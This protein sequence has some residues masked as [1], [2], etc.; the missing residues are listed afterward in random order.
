V[1]QAQVPGPSVSEPHSP[2]RSI[3][4]VNPGSV[5]LPAYDDMHPFKHHVET[6]SPHARYAIVE[7]TAQ[8]WHTELR[9]VPY[10]VEPMARMAEQR[11]RPDWAI[12]L[13]TGR[14]T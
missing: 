10:D 13:R 11:G 4:I 8:G 1:V 2:L 7:K 3:T 9:S 12:A 14:M 6:A 5:G